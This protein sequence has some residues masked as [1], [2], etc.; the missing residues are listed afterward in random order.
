MYV[1]YSTVEDNIVLYVLFVLKEFPVSDVS[2][3]V[4]VLFPL[5]SLTAII[6]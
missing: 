2:R 5:P 6:I 4:F 3:I 1:T